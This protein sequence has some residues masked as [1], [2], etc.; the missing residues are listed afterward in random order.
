[1]TKDEIIEMAK[2]AGFEEHQAKFDTRFEPFARL[3]AEHVYAK[4]LELPESKQ[5]GTISIT[6]P[7][8][9][10]CENAVGHKYFRWKKPTSTYKPI[11]LYTAPPQR[12]A[13]RIEDLEVMLERQTARIVDLQTH[14]ENFDGEDR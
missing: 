14:I 7:I 10:L 12:M 5:S 4:Y 8:G 9:Y 6:T 3:V 1:M 2:Q 13:K 11:A